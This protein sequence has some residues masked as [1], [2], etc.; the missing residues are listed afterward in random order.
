M[1]AGVRWIATCCRSRGTFD[2]SRGVM[3]KDTPITTLWEP[4]V[5]LAAMAVVVS[6]SRCSGS[7]VTLHRAPD[8]VGSLCRDPS[9]RRHDVGSRV[10]ERPIRVANS[11]DHVSLGAESSTVSVVVGGDGAGKSTLLRAL[12]GLVP[13]SSGIARRPSKKEIG[14]VPATG[15]AVCRP[16]C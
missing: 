8:A 5:V 7:G 4:L 13:L 6:D 9:R 16:H 2:I 10:R 12:V 11:V 14:Y 3:L 1:A 15:R